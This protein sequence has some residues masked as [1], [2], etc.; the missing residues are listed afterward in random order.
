M[1]SATPSSLVVALLAAVASTSACVPYTVGTSAHPVAAGE[2]TR[3]T[4]YYFIPNAVRTPGDTVAAPLY[5]ADFELRHG[6]DAR[7]DVGVRLLPAGVAVNYKR[8]L[9]QDTSRTRPAVAFMTGAG[10]VNAGEHAHFE[11]TLI[12]SGRQGGTLTPYGGLRA[13]QV[14]PITRGA[15]HDSPTAGLFGGL[16]IGDGD[17]I[18]SPEIGVFYDRSALHVRSADVIVVPAVTL[19]RGPREGGRRGPPWW[20]LLGQLMR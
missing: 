12:A 4:S 1:R 5:G 8:R 3:A 13:M 15:V 9:G 16:R 19:E 17:F 10:I 20:R 2:T 7:S 11:A 6:L 14:V 18:I